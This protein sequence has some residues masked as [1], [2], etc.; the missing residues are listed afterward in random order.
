MES[1]T[2]EG[3]T[4]SGA[5][6]ESERDT[7]APSSRRRLPTSL[8]RDQVL[9]L[10]EEQ[11]G[12]RRK[13]IAEQLGVQLSRAGKIVNP[14]VDEGVIREIDGRLFTGGV[15]GKQLWLGT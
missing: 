6:G 7:D 11:R 9:T 15:S 8:R 10:V 3:R 1:I 12:L 14:L 4:E 2:P 13:D 5:E